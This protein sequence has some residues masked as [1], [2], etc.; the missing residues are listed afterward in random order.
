MSV[1]SAGES[2]RS[3]PKIRVRQPL[4]VLSLPHVIPLF[5][6]AEARDLARAEEAATAA[7]GA[8]R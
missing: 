1:A 6:Q 2:A 3:L 7:E 5:E 8:E 4:L